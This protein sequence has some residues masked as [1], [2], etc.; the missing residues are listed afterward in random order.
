[1]KN[2]PAALHT[3]K[4]HAEVDGELKTE[5]LVGL[6]GVQP[7]ENG[8]LVIGGTTSNELTLL[9][10]NQL[11]GLGGPTILLEGRLD[12][13]M[14]IDQDGL[15]GGIT[16]IGTQDNRRELESVAIH[17]VGAG[18]TDDES[19]QVERNKNEDVNVN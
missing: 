14:A 5:L 17:L 9:V 1:M 10:L 19:D 8:T 12:I 4:A 6:D 7:S 16:A 18:V 2:H 3:L 13:V 11:E 15:L